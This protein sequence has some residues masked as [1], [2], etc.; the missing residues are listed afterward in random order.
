V[1]LK[2][3]DPVSAQVVLRSASGARLE[4]QAITASNSAQFAPDPETVARARAVF[5]REG[6]EVG[7][8]VG[9]SFSI[10]APV[11]QFERAF[12]VKLRA[13]RSGSLEVLGQ[14]GSALELPITALPQSVHELLEAVTFSRPMDFGPNSY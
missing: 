6:F 12:S 14:A 1:P 2:K 5:A 8:L 13:A 4:G 11:R 9:N 7:D 3:G 10:S